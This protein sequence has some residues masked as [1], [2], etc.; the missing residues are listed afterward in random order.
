MPTWVVFFDT[1]EKR[2]ITG[3]PFWEMTARFLRRAS[4]EARDCTSS[5]EDRRDMTG[6]GFV[7]LLY[8]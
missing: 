2:F 1:S 8:N 4:L 3:C 6:Y 7:Y 5:S